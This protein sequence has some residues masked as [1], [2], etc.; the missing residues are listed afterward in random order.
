[1]LKTPGSN[2]L[3]KKV[4]SI[5][6]LV[7]LVALVALGL[8][9]AA[10]VKDCKDGFGEGKCTGEAC[11][12]PMLNQPCTNDKYCQ[13]NMIPLPGRF[14]YCD[15]D[16]SPVSS[17]G[18]LCD[19]KTCK[20][21][22]Y[23]G[24][25]VCSKGQKGCPLGREICD[26]DVGPQGRGKSCQYQS[27]NSGPMSC[28]DTP[29]P[30]PPSKKCYKSESPCQ[31]NSDCCNS[32][33]VKNPYPPS[34]YSPDKWCAPPPPSPSTC[35]NPNKTPLEECDT[36]SR[37]CCKGYKCERVNNLNIC[38]NSSTSHT[39]G[40][41]NPKYRKHSDDSHKSLNQVHVMD[42]DSDN[43]EVGSSNGPSPPGPPGNKG[44]TTGE[45][46]GIIVGGGVGLLVVI[47]IIWYVM[48]NKKPKIA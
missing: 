1:M 32:K 34:P 48:K 42:T 39:T 33:C 45:I 13:K 46:V 4:F 11:D 18:P 24:Q 17:P 22:T 31:N 37:L 3:V 8:S 27:G 47:A 12:G 15:T 23:K 16:Y 5:E 35:I 21:C 41:F 19:E 26:K 40:G 14:C 43:D 2:N 20:Y 38:V 28:F 9:I 6:G 10:M 36:I 44:L 30:K 29:D 7:F 25:T